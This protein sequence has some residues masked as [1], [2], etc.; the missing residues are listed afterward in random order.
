MAL[1]L[2]RFFGIKLPPN[3][4]SPLKATSIIDFW[5]RW[6]MT[7]TRFLTAYLYN[8][9]VLWLTRRRAAK[10]QPGFGGRNPPPGAFVSLLMVPLITTMFISGLWHGAGYGFIIWGVIHGVYLVVNHGWRVYAAHRWRDRAAYA[11]MMKPVGFVLTF[12][13]VT[14]AMIFFRATTVRSAVDLVKGAFGVNGV[15]LPHSAAAI[16]A[17]YGTDIKMAAIWIAVLLFIA[18][19]CPNT[20]EILAPYEPALGVKPASTAPVLGGFRI[21]AWG[22]SLP[23]AVAISVVAAVAIFST[24]GP[25]EFLYWQ[26]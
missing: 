22:P 19:V 25:S 26:F 14:I 18:L 15:A 17:T 4:N 8:P 1:G 23:W 11:R 7:L 16:A 12:V 2:G 10:G 13:A 6:H 21:P 20:L 9:L 3:F 24:G 5:L